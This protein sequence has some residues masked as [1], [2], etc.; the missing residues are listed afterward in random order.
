MNYLILVE[1]L[2]IV[3]VGNTNYKVKF[4]DLWDTVYVA[5]GTGSYVRIFREDNSITTS[6]RI[7]FT[8]VVLAVELANYVR[9]YLKSR[10]AK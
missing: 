4:E 1:G 9:K 3:Q 5:E 8:Q 7:P 10:S 6:N 2:H